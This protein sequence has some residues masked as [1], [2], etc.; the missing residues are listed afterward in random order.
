MPKSATRQLWEAQH[1]WSSS[2]PI[3]KDDLLRQ[4]KCCRCEA[5]F[6][7]HKTASCLEVQLCCKR[8]R[9]V[10]RTHS[11]YPQPKIGS[12]AYMRLVNQH[13]DWRGLVSSEMKVLT[14][15][16]QEWEGG[17]RR[18]EGGPSNAEAIQEL[19]NAVLQNS[20]MSVKLRTALLSALLGTQHIRSVTALARACAC[21]RT[22]IWRHW[23][24][25]V[26]PVDPKEILESIHLLRLWPQASPRPRVRARIES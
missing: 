1:T 8:V 15:K 26:G 21:D 24:Q 5:S 13:T 10:A 19:A 22:T 4:P 12:A 11:S 16:S 3:C 9:F 2:T 20:R 23:K 14:S 17:R 18:K 7:P 25:S 6:K